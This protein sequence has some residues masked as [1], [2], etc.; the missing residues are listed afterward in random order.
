M[1]AAALVAGLV[2]CPSPAAAATPTPAEQAGA[3][4]FAYRQVSDERERTA[5]AIVLRR[6]VVREEPSASAPR[7][8]IVGVTTYL[9]SVETVL[10]L[11]AA[12]FRPGGVVAPT[13]PEVTIPAGS[14]GAAP[15]VRPPR[16]RAW[17]FVR[18]PGD[19]SPTGWVPTDRLGPLSHTDTQLI[20]DRAARRAVLRRGGR[21]VL[22]APVAIGR[23]RSPTPAGRAYVREILTPHPA[24]GPYG[25]LALGL[26]AYSDT[27]T[28]WPG[29]G[30][31]G[32]HG[33]NEPD[34]IGGRVT[35]GCVR[36]TNRAIARLGRAVTV[37]TPVLIR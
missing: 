5:A 23:A 36:L 22:R 33:T 26:S 32:I 19:G 2:S 34:L 29:G 28:D 4:G 14:P 13:S 24:T 16:I 10:V 7:A 1:G 27:A 8:G 21:V 31:V 25:V 12:R 35:H 20:I 11:G 30:Q 6:T 37:G 3:A 9:G 17:S 18:F 15:V